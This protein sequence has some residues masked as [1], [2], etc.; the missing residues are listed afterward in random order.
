MGES[1]MYMKEGAK[2]RSLDH[3][4]IIKCHLTFRFRG[5]N[6]LYT[7]IAYARPL[8]P[9]VCPGLAREA[10]EDATRLGRAP[11][12]CLYLSVSCPA[13][14]KKAVRQTSPPDGPQRMWSGSA[15]GAVSAGHSRPVSV[16]GVGVRMARPRLW[17]GP[18]G[19]GGR[20]EAEPKSSK[21]EAS[22]NRWALKCT[23]LRDRPETPAPRTHTHTHTH[24][25]TPIVRPP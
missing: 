14:A 5:T 3:P 9:E 11:F 20:S 10:G 7:C 1:V 23:T 18:R 15:C 17:C 12:R 21:V 16:L 2:L 19:R 6:T 8:P 4:N 13:H 24:T 22:P 25:H